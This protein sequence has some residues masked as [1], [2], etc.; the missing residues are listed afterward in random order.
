MIKPLTFLLITLSSFAFVHNAR[1]KV[2]VHPMVKN[3]KLIQLEGMFTVNNK[4]FLLIS[5]NRH[6]AVNY[7]AAIYPIE[8]DGN[9][10]TPIRQPDV[11]LIDV[12]MAQKKSIYLEN[13]IINKDKT[14][15]YFTKRK[16][17]NGTVCCVELKEDCIINREG[18]QEL[19]NL[20][21][22]TFH[23]YAA[24]DV[25]QSP[26]Q[27]KILVVGMNSKTNKSSEYIFKLYTAGMKELIWE[28]KLN[29][30]RRQ[31][32][33]KG[34]DNFSTGREPNS[35]IFCNFLLNNNGD[36]FMLADKE[37]PS[38]LKHELSIYALDG[39]TGEHT[40]T[41]INLPGE[42][43]N[44]TI[45]RLGKNG[46]AN[47]MAFYSSIKEKF[48]EFSNQSGVKINSFVALSYDG[49]ET[50]TLA[51]FTFTDEQQSLFY[52]AKKRKPK[53]DYRIGG[54]TISNSINTPTGDLA[55]LMEQSFST[56]GTERPFSNKTNG[57]VNVL[58][59]DSALQ[60]KSC[61]PYERFQS[62]VPYRYFTV[63]RLFIRDGE[64]EL[65]YGNKDEQLQLVN[66]SKP[67]ARPMNLGSKYP[68][69]CSP[70]ANTSLLLDG[71]YL[72][73][74]KTKGSLGCSKISR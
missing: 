65:M 4:P 63:S 45:F 17:G 55:I 5:E 11:N 7:T 53:T 18:A 61:H 34:S 24:F 58:I 72:V 32:F 12:Y 43:F 9:L 39:K 59:L 29:A 3:K 13:I 50:K 8:K 52:P 35:K 21:L 46:E 54:Y 47:F 36:V 2:N 41:E 30:P 64:L 74:F 56:V 71:N 42:Y 70:F 14:W 16:K 69:E 38:G 67:S 6:L 40:S 20:D 19:M 28:K 15:V 60:F 1:V 73:P 49:K 23:Y 31:G 57:Y 68:Q 33:F 66:I 62:T 26:D 37:N 51:D 10:G 25:R 22:G 48:V 44:G 27:S